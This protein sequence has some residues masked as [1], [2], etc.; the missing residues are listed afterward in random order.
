MCYF[1]FV[2]H[3]ILLFYIC[4]LTVLVACLH[5]QVLVSARSFGEWA[6]GDDDPTLIN[7]NLIN[8]VHHLEGGRMSRSRGLEPGAS[9]GD[10][11]SMV[12]WS[13]GQRHEQLRGRLVTRDTS[14]HCLCC[15]RTCFESVSYLYN[16]TC[17]LYLQ[18]A[19]RCEVDA[20]EYWIL[21]FC[22]V[23]LFVILTFGRIVGSTSR[24][25]RWR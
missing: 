14:L 9:H 7:G 24:L 16:S 2:H 17:V 10:E 5:V 18:C 25:K 1:N 19:C 11:L 3:V 21:V 23:G 15:E 4:E 12:T 22:D 20:G 13:S 8:F 6:S